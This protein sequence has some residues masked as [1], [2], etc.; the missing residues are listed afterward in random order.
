MQLEFPIDPTDTAIGVMEHR[1]HRAES[2]SIETFFNAALGRRH[3]RQPAPGHHRPGAGAQPGP[4]RLHRPGLRRQ[5]D[6]RRGRRACRR[7]QSVADIPGEVDVAIVAV[8]AD[9]VQDVVLD[10]AAKGVHGLVVISSRLRRDRRGGPP[11]AAPA[12]R[13]GPVLRPAA[14]RPQLPRRHQH[15]P[16]RLAQRLAVAGDAAARPGRVLLPVRRARARRSSRRSTTAASACR[17][18]SAPAT[19]PTS[20]A[21]TSCST[22]RRTTPPRSSCSTSSRS[23]TRA[24]SPGSPAG[25]R[26]ASRSSRSGRAAPPRACR[27]ATRSADRRAAGRRSTRCSGRPA[28]SRSTRWTRCSTSPSCSPTSR[29]RAGRRVAVVGNSD[30]LGLLAA[31]AAAAVGLVVNKLGRAGRRRDGRGLRGR[32]RRRHRR[33]RG[34]LGGRD[35]HPAAQRHRR[36]GRQRAGRGR[37]AVR[38]AAGLHLP[39]RRGRARAA[40]RAR[41]GRLDGRPR[42]GAVVPRRR[43]RGPRAGR[44]VEYAVWLRTPDGPAGDLDGVDHARRQ[45]AGHRAADRRT[46]T[47]A[48]ST[49]D[50]LRTLLGGLRHRPVG[51]APR[52]PPL[53]EAVAR[54]R[55]ARLGR[56]AQ[57]HR[58]APAR[59]ARPGPR[60]AQHRQRRRRCGTP[61]RAC[62]E[63]IT[64]RRRRGFVVQRIAPPG[65]P[66]GDRAASRTRCSARSCRSA[67]PAR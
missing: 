41:R 18:S 8:P 16:R 46:R 29:C 44:V 42:L 12:G 51:A 20:P 37:R 62:N 25:S 5:P 36:G 49:S 21:T 11:A 3:R 48:T 26:G 58:R 6:G 57:G 23:A 56:R 13:A 30:A 28:S 27:W 55:G 67:S 22:G 33:P 61:G 34:R 24:S 31:D 1:E 15:R 4:R 39:R 47:A 40:A 32:P 35:L 14:D 7:T 9:A 52:R 38:Q 2:A 53:D 66:G 50:E 59:P 10:C 54:R 19:A 60:V 43:G 63:I 64:T 65:R 45:A 17:R